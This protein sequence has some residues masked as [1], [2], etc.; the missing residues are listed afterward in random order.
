MVP[1][2]RQARQMVAGVT[3]YLHAACHVVSIMATN[4]PSLN[5]SIVRVVLPMA[6][7]P[8]SFHT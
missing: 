4:S 3:S 8:I 7:T 1:L 2:P 5:T 6:V